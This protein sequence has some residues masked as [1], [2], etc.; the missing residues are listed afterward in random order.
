LGWDRDPE[1]PVEKHYRRFVPK[2]LENVKEV[3]SRPSEFNVYDIKRGQARGASG[4]LFGGGKS[5]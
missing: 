1:N 2:E 3:M 5:D 4:G